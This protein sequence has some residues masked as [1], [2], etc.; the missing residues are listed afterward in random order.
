MG[1]CIGTFLAGNARIG[2][3]YVGPDLAPFAPYA[4]PEL[5]PRGTECALR[6]T[7]RANIVELEDGSAWRIWPGDLA[8]PWISSTRLAVSEIHDEHWTHVLI[9]RLHGTCVRV[10]EAEEDFAPEEIEASLIAD[11]ATFG[12]IHSPP[13]CTCSGA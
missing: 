3:A 2:D 8:I 6:N 10:I 13:A 9:D 12:P 4:R 1:E 7:R 11:A 5:A